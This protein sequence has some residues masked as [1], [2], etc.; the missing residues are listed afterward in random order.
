M[1][2]FESHQSS[3]PSVLDTLRQ[4]IEAKQMV[5]LDYVAADLKAN[6]ISGVEG[7]AT[8]QLETTLKHETLFRH[9][10]RPLNCVWCQGFW[11]LQAWCET[12]QGFS[13]FRID[14]I[15]HL[16]LSKNYFSSDEPG[17]SLADFKKQLEA[18]TIQRNS[19][20]DA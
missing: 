9:S 18:E 10:V 12:T 13:S 6:A 3:N 5:L 11:V 4:A 2:R 17:K 14:H 8:T 1:S 16:E 7:V 19:S 15:Q 20:I